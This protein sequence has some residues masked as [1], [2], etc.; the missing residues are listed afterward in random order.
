[1]PKK[2]GE[3]GDSLKLTVYSSFHSLRFRWRLS[4]ATRNKSAVNSQPPHLT[5]WS[6]EYWELIR[7]ATGG[8]DTPT[9]RELRTCLEQMGKMF[10][11]I[12]EREE[13]DLD[14]EIALQGL[15]GDLR[16]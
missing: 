10:W 12:S 8:K 9:V 3:S 13:R 1:M 14:Y 6:N 7:G 5:P 2:L 11:A 16:L 15:R 4:I